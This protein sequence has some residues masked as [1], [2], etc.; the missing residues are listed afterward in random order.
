MCKTESVMCMHSECDIVC[1]SMCE[2]YI[3]TSR[4]DCVCELIR[5]S[6]C[7]YGDIPEE[8]STERH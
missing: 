3:A 1:E 8:H 4:K 6:M 2:K 5:E 7:A